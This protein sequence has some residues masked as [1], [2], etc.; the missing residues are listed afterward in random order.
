MPVEIVLGYR[1][2]STP[3]SHKRPHLAR[4]LTAKEVE[5]Q[6]EQESDEDSDLA[7][8]DQD[9]DPLQH[10]FIHELESLWWLSLWSITC[11][12]G[13]WNQVKD[14]FVPFNAG[15][16]GELRKSFLIEEHSFQFKALRAALPSALWPVHKRLRVTRGYL[17]SRFPELARLDS[18]KRWNPAEYSHAYNGFR[19]LV[20]VEVPPDAPPPVQSF[21]PVWEVSE[22]EFEAPSK[23][24]RS[25]S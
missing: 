25:D 10:H 3:A 5:E 14:V 13:N 1:I 16:T 19:K 12:L 7:V 6:E 18:T 2:R 9:T 17:G 24:A 8:Q 22:G 15:N 20:N 11:K 23:R 21:N 4:P